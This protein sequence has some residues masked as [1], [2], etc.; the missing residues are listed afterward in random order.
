MK[1]APLN[2]ILLMLLFASC[3]K[4]EIAIEPIL[5]KSLVDQNIV[6][7][8]NLNN[9]LI[10]KLVNDK[11]KLGCNCGTIPFPP[12]PSLTWN[13]LIAAA[14]SAHAKDMATN[15]FFSHESSNGKGIAYRYAIVGYI[16][17]SF[18]ENIASG[19]LN[20]EAV[21]AAWFAS[22]GHCENLM[23]GSVKEMGAAKEATY[24][25]QDFGSK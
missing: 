3:S 11:R 19:Q 6:V 15:N 16:W 7:V 18:A 1:I 14:A 17:K 25:V 9:E 10:L 21:I 5:S 23:S 12:V 22:K 13:N 4:S 8:T 20:E 2:L 24:W